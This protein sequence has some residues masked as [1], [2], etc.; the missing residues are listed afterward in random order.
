MAV[1]KFCVF[2]GA[3]PS[4]K[5]R[6]HIVPQ[7]LIKRTG[8]PS[9]QAYFG[10]NWLSPNLEE[11]R[12]AWK[13]FTFPACVN[14]NQKW[15][16]LE[17]SVQAIIERLLGGD[18]ASAP[19]LGLLLDW[20]DKVRIG[21]WLGM[22]HLNENYRGLSPQFHIDDRVSQKD[23]LLFIFES[24]EREAGIGLSGC[25][26]PIFHKMPSAFHFVINQLHFVSVSSDFVLAKRFGW[27]YV[28]DRRLV[29]IDTD[30]FEARFTEGTGA[31]ES[32]VLLDTPE[33]DH[34]LLMQ[35]IAHQFVYDRSPNEFR[36]YYKNDH[37]KT[38]STDAE[39]AIGH[40]FV[41]NVDPA[42]YPKVP[43]DLWEPRRCYPKRDLF[44]H[45]GVWVAKFQRRLFLD[46]PDFSHFPENDRK[47]RQ[48]EIDGVVAI[49]DRIIEHVVEGGS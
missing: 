29:D 28:V 19:D 42:I 36:R 22:I 6:E 21:I 20:F 35:P 23:R 49:Q 31:I 2:C 47:L 43:S 33:L 39:R 38:T 18:L 10:R 24:T 5:S 14:C 34:R 11:R 25:D 1:G 4:Q 16:Q 3:T 44:Q 41:G 37:V 17:A 45:L 9:R 13:A 32:P 30:G 12:Y 7:W 15:A 40:I 46:T 26:T 48:A 27:P 8:D